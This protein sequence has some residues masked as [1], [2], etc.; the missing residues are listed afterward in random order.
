MES[1]YA[2]QTLAHTQATEAEQKKKILRRVFQQNH[3]SGLT[4]ALTL[5][6]R[7]S[8]SENRLTPKMLWA[9]RA[10]GM[11]DPMKMLLHLSKRIQE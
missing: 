1:R 3:N 7:S 8:N 5:E 4:L 11:T 6:R 9:S 2:L 10:V